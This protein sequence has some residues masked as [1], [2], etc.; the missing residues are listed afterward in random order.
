MDVPRQSARKRHRVWRAVG[1]G[2]AVAIVAASAHAMLSR[3]KAAA[4]TVD[5]GS[6]WLE[7]VKRGEMLRQVQGTGVLVPEHMQWVSAVTAA[8]VERTFVRPGAS[9]EADTVLVELSNPDR[10]LQALEAER[11]L[12]SAEAD[13]TTLFATQ[14]SQRLAQQATVATLQSE[15]GDAT[16]RA[17]ADEELARKGF[18]SQLET[19]QSRGKA[20]EL[21]G[22]TAFERMRLEALSDGMVAQASAQQAQ[23]ARL[24]SIAE[25]RRKEVAAL[26]VRAGSAG[27]LQDLPLQEGQWVTPG[28][29]LAKIVQPERL[30]AEIRVAEGQAKDVQMGQSASID[31]RNGVVRGHVVRMDPA[32]Q[33]GSVKVDVA[34]DEPLP[35]GARPDLSV[36]GMIELERLVDVLYVAR[37]ALAQSQTTLGFFK[38]DNDGSHAVRMQVRVGRSSV[39]TVEIMAGLREGDQVIVSDM[40]AWEFTDRV[41]LK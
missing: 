3:L 40:G 2:G 31:T 23:V 15:A 8:R 36:E 12:A 5:R 34:L 39:K 4:P 24:R 6:V 41:R 17:S 1:M 28:M 22:R 10:E 25:F 35:K 14:K 32:V 27:V 20:D 26:R 13:L 38:L 9:V 19:S 7:T 18:L 30:K 33:A 21:R 37:P 11:Q 29:V 16:R